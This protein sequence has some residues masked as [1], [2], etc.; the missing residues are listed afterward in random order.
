M[1]NFKKKICPKCGRDEFVI[2]RRET[3]EDCPYN[4]AY[5]KDIEGWIYDEEAITRKG[6]ERTESFE[7][8]TCKYGE[9]YDY[10]CEIQKCTNC[11]SEE[12]YPLSEDDV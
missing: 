10:G 2:F 7:E 1:Q 12:F 8:G 3:C 6:L 11:G 9:N 4:G 5:D